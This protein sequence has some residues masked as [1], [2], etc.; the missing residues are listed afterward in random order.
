MPIS[1]IYAC[2]KSDSPISGGRHLF[3]QVEFFLTEAWRSKND[4]CETLN[5]KIKLHELFG[6]RIVFYA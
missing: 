5:V 2:Y 4:K 1:Y 6:K 3:I